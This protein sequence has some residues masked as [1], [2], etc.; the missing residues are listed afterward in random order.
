MII[1]CRCLKIDE[2]G[3]SPKK[4]LDG[5]DLAMGQLDDW[6]KATS[7]AYRKGDEKSNKNS[8]AYC[9]GSLLIMFIFEQP[10]IL[11]SSEC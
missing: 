4:S 11:E 9:D 2:K 7:E 8:R 3:G 1:P 6:E 10:G 5:N